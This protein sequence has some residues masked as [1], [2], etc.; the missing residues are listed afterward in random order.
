MTSS[1]RINLAVF[2]AV[3]ALACGAIAAILLL[4]DGNALAKVHAGIERQYPDVSHID[5][6]ELAGMK[7]GSIIL[8][9]VRE[10]AEYRVSHLA[11]A[12]RVDPGIRPDRFIDKYGDLINGKTAVFYCSVGARST[13]LASELQAQPATNRAKALVN[14][15]HG[16]FGWHNQRRPLIDM[17]RQRTDRIHPFNAFWG[18][19]LDRK[20]LISKS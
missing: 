12:I 2:A 11:G 4:R 18:R 17:Q 3:L 6:E 10:P 8:F 13:M 20:K 14:L 9:D 19:L 16:I 5:A 7:S 15:K 1:K